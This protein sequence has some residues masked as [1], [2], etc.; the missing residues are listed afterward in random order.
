MNTPLYAEH[1]FYTT[2]YID[3][4][5]K[6]SNN[7]VNDMFDNKGQ[8]SLEFG[9][10][11]IKRGSF[12]ECKDGRNIKSDRR[13]SSLP[14]SPSQFFKSHN[15]EDINQVESV[16][17]FT[18]DSAPSLGSDLVRSI[19]QISLRK[20]IDISEKNAFLLYSQH[21][22]SSNKRIYYG[23]KKK[24]FTDFVMMRY[25]SYGHEFTDTK[26]KVYPIQ[27]IKTGFRLYCPEDNKQILYIGSALY[28]F[29]H[30]YNKY[31]E[32]IDEDM[33]A[34]LITSKLYLNSENHSD[35]QLP[36]F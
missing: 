27:T 25:S 36:S 34:I 29:R 35:V 15:G 3:F 9:P 2:D 7:L 33:P 8:D 14:I 4:T 26:G 22:K 5:T 1:D 10:L 28:R 11:A 19:I 6:K 21:D 18:K 12:F 23:N 17:L 32:R 20:K 30:I 16:L 31:G 13:G 24:G